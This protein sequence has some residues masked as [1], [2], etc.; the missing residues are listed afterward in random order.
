MLRGS[1][2]EN[3]PGSV[4]VGPSRLMTTSTAPTSPF[5]VRQ[6][7]VWL[8]M[9]LMSFATLPPKVTSV[10]VAVPVPKPAPSTV[11]SVLPAMAPRT[12]STMPMVNASSKVNA[13][14]AAALRSRGRLLR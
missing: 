9:T 14:A 8:S 2:Y 10:P 1:K 11:T 13:D 5:G 12:G 6:V 4:S 3:P 7:S